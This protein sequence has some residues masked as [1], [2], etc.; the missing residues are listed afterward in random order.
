MDETDVNAQWQAWCSRVQSGQYIAEEEHAKLAEFL[1]IHV[2]PNLPPDDEPQAVAVEPVPEPPPM[3]TDDEPQAVANIPVSNKFQA[4]A[5]SNG[6]SWDAQ[7]PTTGTATPDAPFPEIV[8]ASPGKTEQFRGTWPATEAC[9]RVSIA[10][11]LV[12][13]IFFEASVATKVQFPSRLFL[14]SKKK[15]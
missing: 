7:F 13:A 15:V 1:R 14:N 4:L 6:L 12:V 2:L 9:L 3:E 10:A 11:I 8:R 5:E